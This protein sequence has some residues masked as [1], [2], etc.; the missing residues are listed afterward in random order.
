MSR[1]EILAFDAEIVERQRMLNGTEQ[2]WLEG[3]ERDG[4][5]LLS[6]NFV[7]PKEAAA[8]LREAD[9]TVEATSGALQA[10][11]TSGHVHC[12]VDDVSGD[13]EEVLDMEFHIE[14]GEGSLEHI[15][16]TA[17][18]RGTV[19]GEEARLEVTLDLQ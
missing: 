4:E 12:V 18:V 5:R 8:G 19:A 13:E 2:V 16:G 7:R 1:S 15:A 3:R 6:L 14:D 9:L 10:A 11:L 17:R